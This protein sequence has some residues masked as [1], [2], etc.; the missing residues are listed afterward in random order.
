MSDLC[1][2]VITAPDPE[3]LLAF[4]RQLVDKRLCAA[5]HNFTPIQS[6]YR[7]QGE[8]HERPEGRASLHTRT[9]LVAEITRLAKEQHPYQVP[10]ISTR[11]IDDGSP[12]YL[13]WIRDQT[14]APSAT[15]QP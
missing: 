11:L 10:S 2:L 13:E 8:V 12:E 14:A 1:E 3:W 15:E 6:V 5:A 7:W 4:T 9:G